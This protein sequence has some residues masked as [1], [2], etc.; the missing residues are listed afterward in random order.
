[1]AGCRRPRIRGAGPVIAK[2][3]V[4]EARERRA[5]AR[6]LA[7]RDPLLARDLKVG[8]PDLPGTYDYSGVVDLNSAP[9]EVIAAVCDLDPDPA[10]TI[11]DARPPVGYRAVDDVFSHADIPFPAWEII[12]DRGVAIHLVA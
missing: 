8:R 1:M 9:P 6:Q 3:E 12:L 4:T 10:A 11:V 5:A 2:L 7:Q